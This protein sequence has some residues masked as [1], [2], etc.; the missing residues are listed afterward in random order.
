[1]DISIN[2]NGKYSWAV[3]PS[4]LTISQAVD[5]GK[6]LWLDPWWDSNFS[7][8]KKITLT[9]ANNSYPI[10][11]NVTNVTGGDVN[12]SG[13]CQADFGDIRFVDIDNTTELEQFC[14]YNLTDTFANF[15]V[16]LPADADSDNAILMYYGNATVGIKSNGTHVFND[17]MDYRNYSR[18][19]VSIDGA[20]PNGDKDCNFWENGTYLELI[21]NSTAASTNVN[22]EVTLNNQLDNCNIIMDCT[23]Y[24][25]TGDDASFIRLYDSGGSTLVARSTYPYTLDQT[26]YALRAGGTWHQNPW[27]YFGRRILLKVEESADNETQHVRIK[28]PDDTEIANSGWEANEN[29]IGADVI[30]KF[31]METDSARVAWVKIKYI[32]MYKYI[33]SASVPTIA[34][35][36][37]EFSPAAPPSTSPIGIENMSPADGSTNVSINVNLTWT[38]TSIPGETVVNF[39][40]YFGDSSPPSFV[41]NTT[42]LY[43]DPGTLAFDTTYYWKINLTDDDGDYNETSIL[44]FTTFNPRVNISCFDYYNNS[45]Q[46]NISNSTEE[47]QTT[48]NTTLWWL[49]VS[50]NGTST[51]RVYNDTGLMYEDTGFEQQLHYKIDDPT[52]KY[53][54][55]VLAV[56]YTN[57]TRSFNVT[58][59]VT[60]N[61]TYI[62]GVTL[63]NYSLYNSRNYTK[64]PY[65]TV[66]YYWGGFEN[67]A[68]VFSNF[69]LFNDAS[70]I[71]EYKAPGPNHTTPGSNTYNLYVYDNYSRYGYGDLMEYGTVRLN[72][73]G[74]SSP[75]AERAIDFEAIF[76]NQAP[77]YWN[78]TY[79]F[80]YSVN[81]TGEGTFNITNISDI[82]GANITINISINGEYFENA[83]LANNSAY[84]ITFNATNGV[85]ALKLTLIDQ[86]NNTYVEWFNHTIIL[87]NFVCVDEL[88]GSYVNMADFTAFRVKADEIGWSVDL[89]SQGNGNFTYLAN[90]S[91]PGTLYPH[92]LRF[93][94]AYVGTGVNITRYFDCTIIPALLNDTVYISVPNGSQTIYQQTV[95]STT[96]IQFGV[97]CLNSNAWALLDRTRMVGGLSGSNYAQYVYTIDALYYFRVYEDGVPIIL[98][99]LDGGKAVTIDLDVLILTSTISEVENLTGNLFVQKLYNSS[100]LIYYHNPENNSNLTSIEVT[101]STGYHYLWHNET[102]NPNEFFI[103]FDW[104]TIPG[105]DVNETWTVTAT[106]STGHNTSLTFIPSQMVGPITDDTGALFPAILGVIIAVAL[107]IFGLTLFSSSSTFSFFGPVTCGISLVISFLCEQL[108]YVHI[109][110]I[111]LIIFIAYQL[112]I[113]RYE[114]ST[115]EFSGRGG[116]M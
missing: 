48:V 42:N 109:L 10:M 70:D 98:T 93:E 12:C 51:I 116:M 28:N 94:I 27:S 53:A 3:K 72:M 68:T 89:K 66:S 61:V 6:F 69:T 65:F 45:L 20:A 99:T 23:V 19:S 8:Y 47:I 35:V 97:W 41:G 31:Y 113:F 60:Y 82:Y 9:N 2:S 105:V 77:G 22:A 54:G 4:N 34:S 87:Y 86:F 112:I 101:N 76:D 84:E 38:N 110:Q 62:T 58:V 102:L 92:S 107:A 40:I 75:G 96:P 114:Y 106:A 7:Y 26:K 18:F 30:E 11:I 43:Y 13:H 16:K 111:V 71:D 63:H 59:N 78:T 57:A 103:Y 100:L 74:H 49:N 32:A 91:Y 81:S 85:N 14:P 17:F 5:Q 83:A 36:S 104:S 79:S 80:N 50:A 21:D 1:M 55:S 64:I 29:N 33:G 56:N 46:Y 25:K 15:W 44:S 67:D 108:W 52:G 90:T 37:G 73:T 39:S 88:D 115:T 95:Q 24:D